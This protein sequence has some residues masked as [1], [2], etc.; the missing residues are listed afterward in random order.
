MDNFGVPQSVHLFC[1]GDAHELSLE[2]KI[3]YSY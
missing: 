3:S 2:G 1:S